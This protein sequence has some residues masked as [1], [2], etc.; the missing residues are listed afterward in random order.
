[1]N[2]HRQRELREGAGDALSS[3]FEMIATPAVFGFFGW[4]IDRQIDTFPIFTLALA[5]VV[6]VYQIWR[7]YQQYSMTMDEM[8]DER[9]KQYGNE[10]Q[11]G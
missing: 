4:L 1:V 3:S 11:G 6:L 8:L 7:V 2:R 9:R 10:A 5:A